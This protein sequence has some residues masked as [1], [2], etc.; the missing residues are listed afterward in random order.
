MQVLYGKEALCYIELV[1]FGDIQGIDTDP[2]YNRFES[3]RSVVL[4]NIEPQYQ[5]FF[6]QPIVS[7]SRDIITWY[8]DKWDVKPVRLVDIPRESPQRVSYEE[9][10]HRTYQHYMEKIE[11]L[12]RGSE[13]KQILRSA[14]KHYDEEYLYCYDGKVVLSV[15]GMKRRDSVAK[16]IGQIVHQ[17]DEV[18][19]RKISFDLGEGAT[20]IHKIDSHILREDGY[21]MTR[22]DIPPMNLKEG[23]RFLGWLPEP[24][25]YVITGDITFVAQYEKVDI[26]NILFKAGAGGELNGKMEQR[27]LQGDVLSMDLIPVVS[28]YDDFVFKVWTP[29]DPLGYRVGSDETFTALFEK[30][31]SE[32]PVVPEESK[33][34]DEEE[35]I[36]A[37]FEAGRFGKL[38]GNSECV[39]PRGSRLIAS[40]IPR[41]IPKKKYDFTG[42]DVDPLLEKLDSDTT[43]YAEYAKQLPWYKRWLARFGWGGGNGRNDNDG[44]V[45][46]WWRKFLKWLLYILL[47]LLLLL[48]LLWMLRS[49]NSCSSRAGIGGGDGNPAVVAPD[50]GRDNGNDSGNGGSGGERDWLVG[51]R[52]GALPARPGVPPVTGPG[53]KLPPIISNPGVPDVIANRLNL[54]FE[55]SNTDIRSFAEDFKK[56][57]SDDE[58]IVTGYDD[59]V[60]WVQIEVP[61]A[62]REKVKREINSKLSDYGF[63]VVDESLFEGSQSGKIDSNSTPGWHL[64]AINA[65]KGWKVTKGNKDIVVAVVDDGFDLS[66]KLLKDKIVKPYNVFTQSN[67]IS[68]GDGH[69]THVAGIAVAK[70]DMKIGVSGIAPD[71][72]LMPVQVYDN[73]LCPFSALVNGIMYAIHEGADVV[74]ISMGTSFQGL[75]ILPEEDQEAIIENNFKNEEWV[76]GKVVSVAL[77]KNVILV[78]AAGNDNVL[79]LLPPEHRP[80]GILNVSATGISGRVAEFSNFGIGSTVSAPGVDIYS[81]FPNN[82]YTYMSGTSMAAPIVTGTIALMKSLNRELTGTQVATIL[83]QTGLNTT[84][85]GP[86]IQV[87]KAL[88]MVQSG[89]LPAPEEPTDIEPAPGRNDKPATPPQQ[90]D[91]TDYESIRKMIDAY[92]RKI[93]DLE[94]LLPENQ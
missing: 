69:G 92:K 11:A 25:D 1:D 88:A 57:Y 26:C 21:V 3:V 50:E 75:G 16:P 29:Y 44:Q 20:F 40:E 49:C 83:E 91:E 9:I 60:L 85:A 68:S 67:A 47:G 39:K 51:E 61:E 33:E 19:R 14:L 64:K 6:T 54:Y 52:D 45:V 84:N 37:Y 35:Y 41:V 22:E 80:A 81:T 28:P 72:K 89:E 93:E 18:C 10:A 15:W 65:E 77:A 63:F 59:K 87:D 23:Y 5:S 48:L 34:E 2:I 78:F 27:V 90:K 58:Y 7:D 32:Q 4:K 36:T 38:S 70:S 8:T 74:N 79:T 94:K 82:E 73:K 53:G 62:D 17:F 71:C 76:W 31:T 12:A 56:V 86:L 13:E 46:S 43:F 66:H 30:K 24:I 42:W 55:D